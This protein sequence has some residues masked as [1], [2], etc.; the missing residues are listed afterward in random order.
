M[1]MTLFPGER[2]E[3][4]DGKPE[5]RRME[6]RLHEGGRMTTASCLYCDGEGCFHGRAAVQNTRLTGR[7]HTDSLCQQIVKLAIY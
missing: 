4:P 2:P 1:L 6:I 3:Y 7:I 5:G